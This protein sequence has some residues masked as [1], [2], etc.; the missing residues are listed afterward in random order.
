MKKIFTKIIQSFFMF[1]YV[2]IKSYLKTVG[3]DMKAKHFAQ[4][5]NRGT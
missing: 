5:N 4:K 1:V 2:Y 3:I